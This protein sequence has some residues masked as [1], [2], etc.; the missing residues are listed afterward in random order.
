MIRQMLFL[1]ILC[2]LVLFTSGQSLSDIQIPKIIPPS[3]D[4]AALGKYGEIP[5]ENNT[6]VPQIAIPVY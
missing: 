5:V 2:I 1:S 4:A 3:P 6:G